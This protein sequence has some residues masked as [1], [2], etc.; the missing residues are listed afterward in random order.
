ME[1]GGAALGSTY[2]VPKRAA[3]DLRLSASISNVVSPVVGF[4]SVLGCRDTVGAGKRKG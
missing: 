3:R 2:S 1:G 4:T